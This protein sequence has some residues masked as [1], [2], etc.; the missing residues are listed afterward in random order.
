M[1]K[2]KIHFAKTS[3]MN[4]IYSACGIKLDKIF[5]FFWNRK[6]NPQYVSST[7]YLYMVTCKKCL[8]IKEK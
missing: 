5:Q 8:K 7:D 6:N 4:I 2:R 3:K 1:L